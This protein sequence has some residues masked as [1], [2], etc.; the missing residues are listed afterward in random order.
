LKEAVAIYKE[1]HDKDSC[2]NYNVGFSYVELGELEL[3]RNAPSEALRHFENALKHWRGI[4]G[5]GEMSSNEWVATT[6]GFIARCHKS[7]G[8]DDLA[9]DFKDK[10]INMYQQIGKK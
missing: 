1:V 2:G 6:Y 5:E 8:N 3:D 10:C 7:I 4:Y 9:D